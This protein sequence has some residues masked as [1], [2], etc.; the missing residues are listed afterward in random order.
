VK[1]GLSYYIINVIL[2]FCFYLYSL[3]FDWDQPSRA[4][5]RGDILLGFMSPKVPDQEWNFYHV[6][7][8]RRTRNKEEPFFEEVMGS[9]LK[10]A[11]QS[12]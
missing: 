6:S 2:S 3:H 4:F 9:D 12:F 1:K 5:L 10:E 8:I 11:E 7:A